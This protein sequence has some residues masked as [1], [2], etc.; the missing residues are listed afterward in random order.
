M[1]ELKGEFMNCILSQFFMV[2]LLLCFGCAYC[3]RETDSHLHRTESVHERTSFFLNDIIMDTFGSPSPKE[4]VTYLGNSISEH[5]LTRSYG[6][7]QPTVYDRL[8]EMAM[9]NDKSKVLFYKVELFDNKTSI[10]PHIV[11]IICLKDGI[12]ASGPVFFDSIFID[13]DIKD[14]TM[15]SGGV[16][17]M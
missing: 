10:T 15:S 7:L 4:L 13:L 12:S 3:S 6:K 8:N 17:D 11:V 16:W 1:N 9:E 5:E 2:T 14:Y